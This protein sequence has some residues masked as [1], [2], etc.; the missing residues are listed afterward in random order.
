MAPGK[1]I[2]IAEIG[3]VTEGL[4]RGDWFL[5]TLTKIGNYP[6]VVG[7]LYFSRLE[8]PYIDSPDQIC[9]TIDH[10]LEAGGWDPQE[11]IEEFEQ[12]VTQPPY[13]YWAKDSTEMVS[14]AFDRP[15]GT[16]DDV[17]PVSTWA[18]QPDIYYQSW[19]ERLA[20]PALPG[21]VVKNRLIW[22]E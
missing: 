3:S 7:V 20:E 10:R 2:M 15:Q 17:W 5:D 12:M 9:N 4:D 6:G 19:V 16:F 1:P 11:G 14:I 22:I 18:E 8:T 21:V 13:G